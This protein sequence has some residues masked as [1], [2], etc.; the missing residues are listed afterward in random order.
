MSIS[1]DQIHKC[2]GYVMRRSRIFLFLFFF[3]VLCVSVAL[4]GCGNEPKQPKTTKIDCS[5]CN[6]TGRITGVCA[7]CNGK[8]QRVSGLT[9]MI[10]CSSC[11]GTGSV[12]M[13]CPVCSGTGKVLKMNEEHK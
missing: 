9:Q 2:K 6:G 5:V 8:G 1:D 4:I 10:A 13:N 7:V 12:S 3:V 11:G